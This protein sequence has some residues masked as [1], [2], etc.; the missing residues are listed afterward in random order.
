MTQNTNAIKD[1]AKTN[2]IKQIHMSIKTQFS[3]TKFVISL[4]TK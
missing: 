2:A 1:G 3:T 4:E